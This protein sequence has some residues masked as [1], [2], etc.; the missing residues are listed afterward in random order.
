MYASSADKCAETVTMVM[1]CQLREGVRL[2]ANDRGGWSSTGKLH[3]WAVIGQWSHLHRLPRSEAVIKDLP[4][5]PSQ[6]PFDM[7]CSC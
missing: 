5:P 1:H 7:A 6:R 4:P 2:S 3:A